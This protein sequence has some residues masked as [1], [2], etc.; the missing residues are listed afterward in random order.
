M[1]RTMTASDDYITERQIENMVDQLRA[2]ARK[3]REQLPKDAAQ[4]ALGA[5]N[6]GMRLLAPFRGLVEALAVIARRGSTEATIGQEHQ[7]KRF[8]QNRNGLWVWGGFLRLIENTKALSIG[9]KFPLD[10]FE[11]TKESGAT[12]AEIES[13]LAARGNLFFE[14]DAVAAVIVELISAQE[15]GKEGVLLNNGYANLFYTSSLVV[16]VDWGA[17]VDE[18]RVSAWD[19]A[20]NGWDRGDRVFV[21]SN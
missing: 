11:I 2:A 17:G 7:P 14:I 1:A 5:D 8:F 21:P 4:Q 13:G 19:R 20:G 9:T 10:Y 16:R 18:W 15:G 3:H 6:L 12:D